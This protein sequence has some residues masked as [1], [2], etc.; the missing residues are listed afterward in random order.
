MMRQITSNWVDKEPANEAYQG[1]LGILYA[2]L[3]DHENATRIFEL[4]DNFDRP[5]LHSK[6]IFW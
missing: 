5:F 3:G 1:R 6:N 4:L 2:Q